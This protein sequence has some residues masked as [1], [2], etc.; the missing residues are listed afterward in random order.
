MLPVPSKIV[1]VPQ[2]HPLSPTT[3]KKLI[4]KNNIVVGRP[5]LWTSEI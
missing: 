1:T 4:F 5:K 2:S 3:K